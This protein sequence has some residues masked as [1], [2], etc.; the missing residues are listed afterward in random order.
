MQKIEQVPTNIITGALGVGKTTLI[1]ALLKQKPKSERW[2][3]LVNEFGEVGVDGALLACPEESGIFIREVPGGCMCCTS[4]LPMQIALNMLLAKAKPHRLLIEPTGLGHP[5]EVIQTLT[6]DHYKEVLDIRATLALIDIRKLADK[7]WRAHHT[8]K[9]QLQIADYIIATKSDLYSE[10]L[11]TVLQHYLDEI[12]ITDTPVSYAQHGQIEP[13]LL[14]EK[15]KYIQ[16]SDKHP[17]SHSIFLDQSRIITTPAT[18]SIKVENSGEGYYSCG[19]IRAP[20]ECFD[21]QSVKDTLLS[22]SVDRLKAVLITEQGVV[23]CNMS[24]GCLSLSMPILEGSPD[25]R[26]EFITQD[27]ELAEQTCKTLEAAFGLVSA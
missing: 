21:Y 27:K 20:S 25:S 24:D 19:W 3:V 1:Q 6:A 11:N 5:Q 26:L 7:R 18:G 14:R 10:P 17:H 23:S 2:A 12:G 9:E 16:Q 15:S 13:E 8:F 4:G 22:L